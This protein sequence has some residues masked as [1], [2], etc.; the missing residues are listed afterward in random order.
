M[1]NPNSDLRVTHEILA[2]YAE[3]YKNWGKWGPDD[4]IGTLN[5]TTQQDVVGAAGLVFVFDSLWKRRFHNVRRQLVD[6]SSPG[7][8]P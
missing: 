1:A 3:R 4:E 2:D 7:D 5:Y 8:H 6:V